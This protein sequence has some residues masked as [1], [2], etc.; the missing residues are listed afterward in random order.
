[1]DELPGLSRFELPFKAVH[2]Q[3][4]GEDGTVSSVAS[5]FICREADELYLY[6]CW[7][8]VTGYDP[9]DLKVKFP[10]T[11]VALVMN[12]QGVEQRQP[13]MQ[14]IGGHQSIRIELYD[15]ATGQRIPNWFQNDLHVPHADLNAINIRVPFWNDLI[16]IKLPQTLN[17]APIQIIEESVVATLFPGV[18]EKMFVVGY[19]Y[20][21]STMTMAQPTPVV[22]TRFLA[23]ITVNK[24]VPAALLDGIGAA[25]MSGC[26]VFIEQNGRSFLAAIYTGSLYPDHIIEKNNPVTAL[27]KISN[28]GLVLRADHPTPLVA[29]NDARVR[30][31]T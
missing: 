6:T 28:L 3:C 4:I 5:G 14:V 23:A 9:D 26:P 25:G 27:G 18:G 1:M 15:D 7:H 12:F 21:Y 10:P 24:K 2:L 16:K 11:R 19:P 29:H 17:V 31:A 22:L 13:G 8:V 20:G 30:P